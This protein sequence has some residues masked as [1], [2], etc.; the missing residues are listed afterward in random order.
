MCGSIALRSS[1]LIVLVAVAAS[2]PASDD[3]P[4]PRTASGRVVDVQGR[5]VAGAAVEVSITGQD[6]RPVTIGEGV[7]GVD[8]RFALNLSTNEYGD[9]GLG[10]EAPGFARWGWAG[11]PRGIVGEEIVIHRAIDRAFLDGLRSVRDPE[12]RARRVLEIAASDDLPDIEE[13]FPYLADLRL[14]LAAMVRARPDGPKMRRPDRTPADEALRLL[15]YRADPADDALVAPWIRK[16]WGARPAHVAHIGLAADSIGGICDR[17]REI[18]FA[19]Q[20]IASDRPPSVCHEPV[21]DRTGTHALALFT[22]RYQSWG[23]DM[24]LV[25]RREGKRWVLRGVAENGIQHYRR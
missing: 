12:E 25:T 1:V 8:G 9:L 4:K 14:D 11:F 5:P 3:P 24:H 10:V 16:N 6:Y 21:A 19:D 18:H 22:V 15:A 2:T 17:W 7:S 20:G 13:L 23:Y